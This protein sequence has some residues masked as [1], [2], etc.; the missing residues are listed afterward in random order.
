MDMSILLFIFIIIALHL[1][2]V[3][4]TLLYNEICQGDTF[5]PECPHGSVL[6]IGSAR[7]GRMSYGQCISKGTIGCSVN[8]EDY[9]DS[10]CFGKTAC[11]I[12]IPDRQLLSVN[13]CPKEDIAYLEISHECISGT[14]KFYPN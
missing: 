3:Q 12:F 10:L 8:V 5:E 14:V 2:N 6:V 11:N 13:P 1:S 9:V 4:G 7:F